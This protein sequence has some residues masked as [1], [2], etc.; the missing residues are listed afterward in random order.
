MARLRH[1][2]HG[3]PWDIKQTFS[4]IAPYTLEEASEVAEAIA[5]KDHE[6]LKE[7]LG[8]LLFQVIFH[9]RIAEEIG[10]FNFY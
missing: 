3:C 5:K 9:A 6:N 2:E 8:D 7:E 1:P 10:L 4:T